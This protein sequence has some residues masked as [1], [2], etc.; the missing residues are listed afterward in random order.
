VLKN[1]ED[2]L[3]G[4]AAGS[5]FFTYL[6]RLHHYATT[7]NRDAD[8]L[9]RTASTAAKRT[10]RSLWQKIQRRMGKERPLASIDDPLTAMQFRAFDWIVR[11]QQRIADKRIAVQKRRQRSDREIFERFPLHVVPTYPGDETLMSGPLFRLLR[12]AIASTE[13][14]LGDII[15][16]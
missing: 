10:T 11:N 7:R 3:L 15:R 14:K 2:D 12:P 13:R 4:E 1:Y 16:T 5:I 8:E 6:A 9:Q